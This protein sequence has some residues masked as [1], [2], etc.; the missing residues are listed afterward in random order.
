MGSGIS[1]SLE[2]LQHGESGD[3]D[4]IFPVLPVKDDADV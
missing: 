1:P 2:G 4:A 3:V